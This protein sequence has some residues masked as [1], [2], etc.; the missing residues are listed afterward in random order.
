MSFLQKK[1]FHIVLTNLKCPSNYKTYIKKEKQE[2]RDVPYNCCALMA[3]K[4]LK[5]FSYVAL[6]YL[7]TFNC[8]LHPFK[9]Y[10]FVG[11]A[12]YHSG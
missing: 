10:D 1:K 8:M 7:L 9:K 6:I 11:V 12:R 4:S 2:K 5:S 3:G